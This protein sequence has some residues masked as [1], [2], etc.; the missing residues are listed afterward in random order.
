MPGVVLINPEG[1][2]EFVDQTNVQSALAGGYR[3]REGDTATVTNRAGVSRTFNAE[4]LP[5]Q[6]GQG[7]TLAPVGERVA[8][9]AQRFDENTY[10]TLGQRLLTGVEGGASTLSLGFSDFALEGFGADTG[11]RARVNPK[12]RLAGEVAGILATLPIGGAGAA[13][14]VA[15]ATPA[16][17]LAKGARGVG[18]KLGGGLGAKVTAEAIEGLG[19]GIGQGISNVAIA[20]PR[21][22][23]ESAFGELATQGLYGLGFGAA[24]GGLGWVAE[25]VGSRLGSRLAKTDADAALPMTLA[26]TPKGVLGADAVSRGVKTLDDAV[27]KA[28]KDTEFAASNYRWYNDHPELKAPA[29]RILDFDKQMYSL[30][31][32]AEATLRKQSDELASTVEKLPPPKTDAELIKDFVADDPVF[33]ETMVRSFRLSRQWHQ[34][35]KQFIEDMAGAGLIKDVK[36]AKKDLAKANRLHGELSL[37]S[38]DPAD[39]LG[40]PLPG[41]VRGN[42]GLQKLPIDEQR[43]VANKLVEYRNHMRDIETR[44][45]GPGLGI[46]EPAQ[47]VTALEKFA[48]GE[49]W[50]VTA[51]VP[52]GKK[53][54]VTVQFAPDSPIDEAWEAG[55]ARNAAILEK[56]K[57]LSDV[58]DQLKAARATIDEATLD[59]LGRSGAMPQVAELSNRLDGFA[60]A[61]RGA[62]VASDQKLMA[63]VEKHLAKMDGI[64]E[65]MRSVAG[66][67][68]RVPAL[69][70]LT[71]LKEAQAA[72]HSI[73]AQL[74]KGA[75]FDEIVNLTPE[76]GLSV[77]SSMNDY[78]RATSKLAGTSPEFNAA[79][80]EFKA[81]I[82]SSMK[83]KVVDSSAK[84]MLVALGIAEVGL[85]DF[86]GP[87]DD[88]AKL[89][90]AAK[91]AGGGAGKTSLL[92]RA[93]K[94]AATAA[95]AKLGRSALGVTKGGSGGLFGAASSALGSSLGSQLV[96]KI[97]GAAGNL[98]KVTGAATAR[99]G[100]ATASLL[101]GAGKRS[102]VAAP[103]ASAVLNSVSFGDDP[104][105]KNQPLQAAY[106]DRLNELAAIAANPLAAQKKL[107]DNL[108][109]VRQAN[110]PTGD[111]AEMHAVAVAQ[112]LYDEAPKDP[113][114]MRRLGKSVWK[115]SE[116]DIIKFTSYMRG[117]LDPVGVY[118]R[119][120]SG[121]I[122]PQEAKAVRDLYPATFSQIQYAIASD[123]PAI[124]D[125]SKY[126]QRV[127]LTILFGVPVDTLASKHNVDFV[128]QQFADRAGPDSQSVDLN[129]GAFKDTPPTQAQKLASR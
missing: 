111:E 119:A 88:L 104:P 125:K 31:D 30:A 84:D 124:Q 94:S 41:Q 42:A 32:E 62:S 63:K 43:K 15:L 81:G 70:E 106:K 95:G 56:S 107:N 54:S 67:A 102:R 66:K 48:A 103:I 61:L 2:E 50:R 27:E 7:A 38:D 72:R 4:D 17:L 18:A 118:E 117:A 52:D 49:R 22:T 123:L 59:Q 5:G 14:K 69:P 39:V 29:K 120:V 127:R 34:T 55:T 25:G 37:L 90:I 58:A 60:N 98:S 13:G 65:D 9:Q 97:A 109:P 110:F 86:E 121:G 10:G 82:Q 1:A 78:Y 75:G 45:G 28:A 64:A 16:G 6:L 105:K 96:T 26:G 113:G 85:P 116:A 76:Q 79:L 73:T 87:V 20:D 77:L 108:K 3:P 129:A 93:G 122:T 100:R 19:Q 115:P 68:P 89:W 101:E 92:G 128:Q 71:L 57:S 36:A 12:S 46:K 47:E 112:K 24:A 44:Y 23:A 21:F 74:P 126:D 53:K 83:G 99:I 51:R 35:H 91:V 40:R 114:N 8:A 11:A 33:S 80:Q